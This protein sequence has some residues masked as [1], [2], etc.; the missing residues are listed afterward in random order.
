MGEY[1]IRYYHIK[2]YTYNNVVSGD[3]FTVHLC[4]TNKIYV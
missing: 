2:Y 3:E 4:P 1:I